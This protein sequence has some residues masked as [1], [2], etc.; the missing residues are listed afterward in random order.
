MNL[1]FI[2]I[3]DGRECLVLDEFDYNN[4][5]YIILVNSINKTDFIIREIVNDEI[6]GIESETILQKV[7]FYYFDKVVKKD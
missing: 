6:K 3:E 5:K 2:T 4:K 7:L 1:E